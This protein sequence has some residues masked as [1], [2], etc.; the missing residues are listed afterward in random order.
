MLRFYSAILYP[1]ARHVPRY[2]IS[3]SKDRRKRVAEFRIRSILR[4]EST[5]LTSQR[6]RDR[7]QLK[8]R[9]SNKIGGLFYSSVFFFHVP[10]F[11]KFQTQCDSSEE[12]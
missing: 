10:L 6:R 4:M 7:G 5:L 9:G 12:K 8:L 3:G 11:R 1:I 2:F